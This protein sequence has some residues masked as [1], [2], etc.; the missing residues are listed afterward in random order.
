M[1]LDK[2][3]S[4]ISRIRQELERNVVWSNI[5]CSESSDLQR[6]PDSTLLSM[7]NDKTKLEMKSYF[8]L[9]LS[10][11]FSALFLNTEG[12]YREIADIL[13]EGILEELHT[14]KLCNHIFRLVLH[15]SFCFI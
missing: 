12:I 10:S 7:G 3:V 9:R 8:T 11:F 2:T 5:D 14:K 13:R 1:L 6:R 15:C 4:R